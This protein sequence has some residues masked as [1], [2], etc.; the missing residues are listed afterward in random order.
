MKN[1]Q[2]LYYKCDLCDNFKW[3]KGSIEQPLPIRN[4]RGSTKEGEI[5]EN[6][7]LDEEIHQM[8]KKLKQQKKLMHGTIKIGIVMF[9][10]L[11]FVM[12]K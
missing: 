7:S 12:R 8:K 11:V 3:C 4:N 2:R 1:P 9:F 6:R 5:E 10:I